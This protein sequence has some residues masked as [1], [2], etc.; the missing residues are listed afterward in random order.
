[1]KKY[2]ITTTHTVI[3]SSQ[4]EALQKVAMMTTA[5]GRPSKILKEAERI[6]DDMIAEAVKWAGK[7]GKSSGVGFITMYGTNAANNGNGGLYLLDKDSLKKYMTK[8]RQNLIDIINNEGYSS[9][10]V[11]KGKTFDLDAGEPEDV[12][13]DIYIRLMVRLGIAIAASSKEG[14]NVLMSVFNKVVRHQASGENLG[15]ETE[16]G[17]GKKGC[18]AA[19]KYIARISMTNIKPAYLGVDGWSK[20]LRKLNEAA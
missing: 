12:V 11:L 17:R 10:G 20:M 8:Q 3:A 9:S 2:R 6:A 15:T 4:Q 14:Y 7:W 5:A 19:I 1:M 16:K 18:D 13:F